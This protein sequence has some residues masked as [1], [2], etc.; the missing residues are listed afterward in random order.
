[1]N[2]ENV[3]YHDKKEIRHYVICFNSRV[4]FGPRFGLDRSTTLPMVPLNVA[5]SLTRT[6]S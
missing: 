5:R 6:C 2:I 1:M 3:F 4:R